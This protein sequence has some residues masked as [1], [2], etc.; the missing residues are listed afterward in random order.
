MKGHA[1]TVL[2]A[3]ARPL[4]RLRHDID[5]AVLPPSA[6]DA[7]LGALVGLGIDIRCRQRVTGDAGPSSLDNLIAS[8]DAV[9]LAIGP[10][11]AIQF[12]GTLRL[13]SA[14]RL[15]LDPQTLASS[16]PTVFG[17]GLH[18]GDE[19]TYSAIL[20][21]R[22]GRRAAVS[23]DRFLQGASLT[24]SRADDTA[25]G[26][27][28]YVNTARH[29]DAP[30]VQPS[31]PAAGYC[32]SEAMEEAARCFP[33]HCLECVRACA[34]LAHYKTYPKRAVREIYNNDSIVMGNRK[35][36]R[37]IDSCALCGLCE[38]L[39]PNDLAL[40]DVCLNARRSMVERGHMPASHHDFALRDMAF[41]R[42]TEVAFVRHQPG[43]DRSA[44]LF[45]PGCQAAGFG[46]ASGR[47][48]LPPSLR[49]AAGRRRLHAR[50][51][52]RAGPTGQDA[53]RF[54]GRCSITFAP[55]GR[56]RVGRASSRRA[57]PA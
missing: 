20:S 11:P 7:D 2:E 18:G 5:P 52:R 9:L 42:S 35:S 13:T 45:F 46:A 16:H 14:G 30:P 25:T 33:C 55:S 34:Y 29:A 15:D 21:V 6:I 4:E 53:R 57:R 26:T 3:E 1:V 17:S 19:E 12:S 8:Y 48:G 22:D 43:H 10:G 40:G 49:S 27:C 23:I 39:C 36:N 50:L 31:D 54:T 37:M 56:G 44:V 41:S 24:A 38:T 28:L 32:H 51:L 47:G